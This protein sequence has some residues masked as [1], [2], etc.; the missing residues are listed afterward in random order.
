MTIED[1]AETD[2]VYTCMPTP[3]FLWPRA[4]IESLVAGMRL[5]EQ[6]LFHAHRRWIGGG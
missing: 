1:I 2:A 3:L 4:E 5:V 6:E